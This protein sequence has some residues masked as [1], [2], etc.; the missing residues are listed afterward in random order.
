MSSEWQIDLSQ[1]ILHTCKHTRT[2]A[3]THMYLYTIYIYNLVPKICNAMNSDTVST[4]VLYQSRSSKKPTAQTS[5]GS[6]T[7]PL[8][9]HLNNCMQPSTIISRGHMHAST[10]L[11]KHAYIYN[12]VCIYRLHVYPKIFLKFWFR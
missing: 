2:H 12:R 4:V 9:Y 8:C 7:T 1:Y 11:H 3:R 10:H 6:G 5:T